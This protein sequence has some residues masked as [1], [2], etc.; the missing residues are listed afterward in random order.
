MARRELFGGCGDRPPRLESLG[1]V[2]VGTRQAR[3][4]ADPSGGRGREGLTSSGRRGVPETP[5]GPLARASS[6]RGYEVIL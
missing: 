2:C 6:Q 4:F 1:Y 3:C 5:P